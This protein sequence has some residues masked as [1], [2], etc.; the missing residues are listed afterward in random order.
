MLLIGSW[1][2][3]FD[4]GSD[5]DQ[6]G[7]LNIKL[8]W[9]CANK[10]T[11]SF[12]QTLSWNMKSI[13]DHLTSDL[14]ANEIWDVVVG[15]DS[16]NDYIEGIWTNKRIVVDVFC[17]VK[18]LLTFVFF[19]SHCLKN[20]RKCVWWVF[21]WTNCTCA[22][23]VARC[24]ST[25]RGRRVYGHL[26]WNQPSVGLDR[27]TPISLELWRWV[28]QN[29]FFICCVS[30]NIC[31]LFN[32]STMYFCLTRKIFELFFV[33]VLQTNNSNNNNKCN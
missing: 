33:F 24:V 21:H 18:I 3:C 32:N 29:I 25:V 4:Q 1:F 26:S 10:R 6:R 27:R 31:I 12:F 8:Y 17:C 13:Q 2:G 16:S 23:G 5:G 30:Y 7:N 28:N 22:I 19:L 9:I 15:R 14:K 11:I 20:I